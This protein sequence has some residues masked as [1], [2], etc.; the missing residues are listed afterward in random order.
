[1]SDSKR[2]ARSLAILRRRP[3]RFTTLAVSLV[4]AAGLALTVYLVTTSIPFLA[5]SPTTDPVFGAHNACLLQALPQSR[6]GFAVAVDGS[7][8][9]AWSGEKLVVCGR[10]GEGHG[11][12]REL[13]VAGVMTAAYD[14]LGTLWW[15]TG[16]RPEGGPVLWRWEKAAQKPTEVGEVF[17]VALAGH[18]S[19]VVALDGAGKLLSVSSRGEVTA[20]AEL[21]GRAPE[22]SVLTVNSDGTLVMLASEPGIFI[23][24]AQTLRP[25]LQEAPCDVQTAWWSARQVSTVLVACLPRWALTL[26]VRT[27]QKETAAER[28]RTP[29]ILVPQ[30][31]AYVQ[32]CN[33]LPC[34]ASPP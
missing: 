33:A 24:E 7:A 32:P 13:V 21:A 9:A 26:D 15:A 10:V 17:P 5:Q 3:P 34:R 12:V 29:S 28:A 2:A 30:L 14:F 25:L 6:A 19:G 23:F 22:S 18:A 31:D 16:R 4:L 8:V 1:M 20:F 11:V 27:G